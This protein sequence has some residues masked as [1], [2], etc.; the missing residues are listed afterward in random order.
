MF[1]LQKIGDLDGEEVCTFVEE[2]HLALLER[3]V[4]IF[5][6]AAHFADLHYGDAR[7]RDGRVL[8][9]M[10]RA[11]RLGGPGTPRVMEFAAAEFGA[12]QD[13]HPLTASNMM[14]DA[15][16]VR[17]RLPLLWQ[18][19]CGCAVRVW[20]ARK[21]ATMTRHMSQEQAAFV[22]AQVTEYATSLPWT[23]F[24]DLVRAKIIEADPAAEE[25][26]RQTAEAQRFVS[27]GRSNEHGLKVLIAK[28]A[29]GDV[30]MFVA[31]VDRIAH[32]LAAFGDHCSVDV[33]RSKAIG[34]LGNPARALQLLCDFELTLARGRNLS[35]HPAAP[36]DS[37]GPSSP[38]T[39]SGTNRP[40]ADGDGDGEE[41]T[42]R[43]G[44]VHPAQN[45]ADDPPDRHPCPTCQGDSV[46]SGDPS[47][48]L[49]PERIDPKKLLPP[50]T[51]YVHVSQDSFTRDAAGVARFEGV[52]PVSVQQAAEFLGAHCQVTVNPVID[53][54][55]QAAVD[56]YEVPERHREAVQLRSPAD[57]MPFA[58]N[59]GRGMDH[60]H[61]EP[62]I[63]PDDGGPPGQTHP[64]NLGLLVRFH[65]RLK[66]FGRWRLKQPFPGIF[67]WRSPHGRYYLV[68]HTGTQKLGNTRTAARGSNLEVELTPAVDAIEMLDEAS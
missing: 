23:R 44:D 32:I 6:A 10:E 7:D 16:D 36:K 19:V 60:D 66:T 45:D 54:E 53:L 8:P 2:R 9:G 13:M 4:E 11:R 50:A 15:L 52:G 57:A 28:A 34:I 1:E 48:F 26:R 65:H 62:Y 43:E 58:V 64:G 51:L 37:V 5:Y 47:A 17:H 67:I 39:P 12:L 30:I 35:K 25:A 68:D 24:E 3:E 56:A 27:T 22:D 40:D 18:G 20:K 42:V 59:T 55:N 29:A 33:R 46:V 21:V 63:S 41:S 31:M 61:T 49:R 14:A 38:A